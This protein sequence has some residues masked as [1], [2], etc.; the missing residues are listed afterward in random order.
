VSI[1][2]REVEPDLNRSVL[3][4]LWQHHWWSFEQFLSTLRTLEEEEFKRDLGVS[5]GSVHGIVAHLIGA[6]IVWLKRVI[7]GE[8]V[9]R[10]PGTDE[11]PDLAAFERA[12]RETRDDW[13]RV[14]ETA[15]LSRVLH[16][17]NTKGQEFSDPLWLVMTHLVDHGATYRGILISALRLLGRTPPA[18]GVVMYTRTI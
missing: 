6:E 2:E 3:S 9:T 8:S 1:E 14:L 5:Y 15:D 7:R 17:R 12:W 16:Y 18:S 11:L 10:I 13:Q 4:A